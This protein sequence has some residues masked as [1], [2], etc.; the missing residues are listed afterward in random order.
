MPLDAVDLCNVSGLIRVIVLSQ[1]LRVLRTLQIKDQPPA[2][3]DCSK[4]LGQEW[5]DLACTL[6]GRSC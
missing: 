1:F 5:H 2:T 6:A 4:L 3:L